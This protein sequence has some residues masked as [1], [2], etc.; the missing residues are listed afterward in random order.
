VRPDWLVKRVA[1][2]EHCEVK[3]HIDSSR[4]TRH[5]LGITDIGP[6]NLHL[7]AFSMVDDVLLFTEGE[8]VDD[9]HFVVRFYEPVHKVASDE[10][11]PT[12]YKDPFPSYSH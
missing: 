6:L 1:Q 9:D 4:K 7:P 8:I 10:A 2:T 3:D 5:L 11:S 12:R